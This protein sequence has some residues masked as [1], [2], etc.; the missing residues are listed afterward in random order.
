MGTK[1]GGKSLATGVP[2]IPANRRNDEKL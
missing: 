1:P 2:Q